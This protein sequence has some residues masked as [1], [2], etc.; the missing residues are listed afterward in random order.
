MISAEY[1]IY[2]KKGDVEKKHWFAKS[3]TTAFGKKKI[4]FIFL[5]SILVLYI[6]TKIIS[7]LKWVKKTSALV[8][9]KRNF[10]IH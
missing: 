6:D 10:P 2:G 1:L 9:R 8:G 7:Q 4:P 5:S 3:V